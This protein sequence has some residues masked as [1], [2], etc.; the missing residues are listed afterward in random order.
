MRMIF[1]CTC[2]DI[3][4]IEN[5]IGHVLFINNYNVQTIR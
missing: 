2:I 3:G 4:I 1:T 5:I